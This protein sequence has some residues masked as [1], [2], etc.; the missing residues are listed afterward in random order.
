VVSAGPLPEFN[1]WQH[2][3]PEFLVERCLSSLLLGE[4]AE[5][6]PEAATAASKAYGQVR[7]KVV[8]EFSPVRAVKKA[9]H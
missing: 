7:L 6:T 4:A 9:A 8:R 3:R 1:N 2:R 5:K